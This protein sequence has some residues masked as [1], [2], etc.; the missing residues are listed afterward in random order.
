MTEETKGMVRA[1]T[2]CGRRYQ[3][4]CHHDGYDLPTMEMLPER[5]IGLA[6]LTKEWMTKELELIQKDIDYYKSI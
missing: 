2:R 4:S 1:C 5:A 6:N 3:N